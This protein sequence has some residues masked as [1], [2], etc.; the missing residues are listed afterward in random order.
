MLGGYHL[1]STGPDQ[2]RALIAEFRRLGIEKVAPTHCTGDPA[3]EMFAAEYGDD[4]IRAG[5]GLV[6]DIEA[7]PTSGTR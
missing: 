7:S 2:L 3:I 6:I 5:A 1:R 4:F